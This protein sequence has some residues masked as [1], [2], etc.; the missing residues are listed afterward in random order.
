MSV[1]RQRRR[2]AG[3]EMRWA[4]RRLGRC[5]EVTSCSGVEPAKTHDMATHVV[6]PGTGV[7]VDP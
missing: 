2:E 1:M 4:R 3:G 6:W 7:A 5:V